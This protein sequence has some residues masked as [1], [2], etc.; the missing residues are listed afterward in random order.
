LNTRLGL[1]DPVDNYFKHDELL[2]G[3]AESHRTRLEAAATPLL[4]LQI[5]QAITNVVIV[6]NFEVY[7]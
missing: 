4:E 7:I 1:P 5:S 6:Q 2:A 3:D